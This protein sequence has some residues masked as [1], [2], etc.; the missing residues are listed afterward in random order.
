MKFLFAY[1][2]IKRFKIGGSKDVSTGGNLPPLGILY[3]AKMLE[4]NGHK[5]EVLDFNAEEFKKEKLRQRLKSSDA[6]GLTLYTS[7]QS[8]PEATELSIEISEAIREYEPDIPFI[9]GG[10]HCCY[11][12]KIALEKHKADICVKGEGELVINPIAEAIQGKKK[13]STI[14]GVY[15]KEGKKIVNKKPPEQIKDLSTLPMPA[16]HLVEKYDY[17]YVSGIKFSKGKTTS[18]LTSRGCPY[19]CKFCSY[20]YIVPGYRMRKPKHIIEE[21]DHIIDTGYRTL[22][23]VDDN[24]LQLKK[25]VHEVMDFIISKDVNMKIWIENARVDSADRKL[26]EKLRDAGV[27]LIYFGAESGNQDVLDYYNKKI[28]VE[29]TRNAVK[30]SKEM[31]F[32]T[33]ASFILGAPIETRQHIMNTIKFA[34]SLPLDEANFFNF[35]FMI[36]SP[37]WQEAV[38]EGKIKPDEY[39]VI[40]NSDRGLSNFTE[41]EIK[42][43]VKKAYNSHYYNP[44]LWFRELFYALSKRDFRYIKL[45]LKLFT[46]E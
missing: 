39:Y 41:T 36:G 2:G 24:F 31:G 35:V 10:P 14:P 45:G 8:N 13:L 1:P 28:T 37:L 4:N 17:G 9:I 23:F 12:P 21:I 6:V 38:K 34:K 30:L 25:S 26:Y 40:A 15:Y 33:S 16:R 22:V 7:S 11:H 20:N 32:F 19:R 42:D 44:R 5:V 18:V 3:I 29:Q 27:E 46:A 43:Y